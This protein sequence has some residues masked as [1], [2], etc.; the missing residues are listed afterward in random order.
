MSRKAFLA[1]SVLF[2]PFVFSFSAFS[3]AAA[4]RSLSFSSSTSRMVFVSQLMYRFFT[5][6]APPSETPDTRL[7]SSFDVRSLL[8]RRSVEAA[9]PSAPSPSAAAAS[10]AAGSRSGRRGLSLQLHP[11]LPSQAESAS[12]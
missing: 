2:W 8:P 6:F 10:T 7:G 5:L 3:F 11:P 9:G 1:S 12:Q 4:S